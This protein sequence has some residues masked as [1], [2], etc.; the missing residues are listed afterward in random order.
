ML[1]ALQSIHHQPF[2][3]APHCPLKE[4]IGFTLIKSR[5][6]RQMFRDKKNWAFTYEILSCEALRATKTGTDSNFRYS[7][8]RGEKLDPLSNT[9][10]PYRQKQFSGVSRVSIQYTVIIFSLCSVDVQKTAE[11]CSALILYPLSPEPH[12]VHMGLWDGQ[13]DK[14]LLQGW[15]RR[16]NGCC[17]LMPLVAVFLVYKVVYW[18]F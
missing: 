13:D 8:Q 2:L 3:S 18:I 11:V 15:S 17:N 10:F 4:D 12:S 14:H 16:R 7:R 9:I 5:C 6:L 1:R